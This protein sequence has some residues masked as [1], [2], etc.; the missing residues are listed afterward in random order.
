MLQAYGQTTFLITTFRTVSR[1]TEGA[2]SAEGTAA[3]VAA[4]LAFT[5]VALALGLV[6][7]EVLCARREMQAAPFRM[8][9]FLDQQCVGKAPL[10]VELVGVPTPTFI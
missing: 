6:R 4:A 10:R 9:P 3:G 8:A 5:G 7:Q 1:G 2:V